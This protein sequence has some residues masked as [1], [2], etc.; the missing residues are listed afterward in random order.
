MAPKKNGPQFAKVEQPFGAEPPVVYCPI[1][2]KTTLDYDKPSVCEHLAFIYVGDGQA[3]IYTSDDFQNRTRADDLEEF[4]Y[5]E[6]ESLICDADY[7]NEL[8]VIEITSGGMACGPVW[9]T[10]AFGF[11]YGVCA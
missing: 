1:C 9:Y 3:F 7:N 11:D 5:S 6:I 10:D 4:P 2:G 8:L